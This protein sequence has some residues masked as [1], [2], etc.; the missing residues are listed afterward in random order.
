MKI[1]SNRSVWW[2]SGIAM[3]TSVNFAAV[4]A[5]ADSDPIADIRSLL[6]QRMSSDSDVLS[7]V[8]PLLREIDRDGNGLDQKDIDQARLIHDARWRA[9]LVS[10][11]LVYDLNGDLVVTREEAETAIDYQVSRRTSRAADTSQLNANKRQRDQ[12]VNRIMQGDADGNQKLEGLELS[13]LPEGSDEARRRQN[14]SAD[15]A[16]ALI[17]ADPN[18]DGVVTESESLAILSKVA[19]GY[20]EAV[21][22]F[23]QSRKS[24]G[25]DVSVGNCPTLSVPEKSK[26]VLLSTYEG[27]GLSTVSLAGQD[28]VTQVATLDIEAGSDPLTL[29]ISSYNAIIWK[30][31][32]ATDRIAKVYVG[33]IRVNSADGKSAAGVTGLPKDKVGFLTGRRCMGQF[34]EAQSSEA[35]IASARIAKLAGRPV[36]T[37]LA[38]YSSNVI[39]LP[40]GDGAKPNES[41]GNGSGLTIIDGSNRIIVGS[42][43]ELKVDAT[44]A[45]QNGGL[46]WVKREMLR[47]SPGGVQPIN[48]KDVVSEAKPEVYGVLPQQAGLLRLVSEGKIKSI[49]GNGFLILQKIRYPAGLAGAH[50]VKFI[51][52][53]GVPA[54]DGNP[55]HSC[56]FSEADAVYIEGSG[57]CG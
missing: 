21:A 12:Q 31:T 51:L 29:V 42:N 53:K 3:M 35:I 43:G 4:S 46:N 5:R 33:S 52:S 48:I 50:S 49:G 6:A 18:S 9:Q 24:T 56:V 34:S 27:A 13:A 32:G 7:Q 23:Q 55:G 1:R 26:L 44:D 40:S 57:H 45:G 39:N 37:L 15:F 8:G 20:A 36:D 10:R 2:L 17:R 16:Q 38:S 41:I 54:P 30:F 11:N 14:F 19:D 47:F 25:G 28:E 22:K